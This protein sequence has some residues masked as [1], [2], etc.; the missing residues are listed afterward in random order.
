MKIALA[1]DHGGFPLKETISELITSSGHTLIDCGTDSS[2]SVDYPD[3][4]E[5]VCRKIQNCEAERGI[6]ICGSGVGANIA[7]NKFRGIYASVCHDTYTA[8]QGVEH[9]QMNVLCLGARV[10]GS[11]LAKEIVI[12]FINATFSTDERHVRRVEKIRTFEK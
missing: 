6:I 7:A 12:S 8:H 4:A 11:E 10:I 3:F 1:C 5:K 2:A 9:D